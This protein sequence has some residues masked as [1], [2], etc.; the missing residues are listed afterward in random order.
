M[1]IVKIK[2]MDE[3]KKLRD[4]GRIFFGLSGQGDFDDSLYISIKDGSA[5]YFFKHDSD[6][7]EYLVVDHW[8]PIHPK[9]LKTFREIFEDI[10]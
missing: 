7:G 2:S 1:R 6:N 8:H 3:L 10:E 9:T 4:A 5:I